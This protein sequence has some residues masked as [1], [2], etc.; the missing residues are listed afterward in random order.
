MEKRLDCGQIHAPHIDPQCESI[1]VAKQ[2]KMGDNPD[3]IFVSESTTTMHGKS[4]METIPHTQHRPICTRANRVAVG[5]PTPYRKRFKLQKTDWNGYATKLNKLIEDVEP[6]PE[7]YSGFIEKLRVASKRYIPRGCRTNYIPC[8]SGKSKS[9][10]KEYKKQYTSDPFDKGT[11]TLMNNM[12]EEKKKKWEEVITT[13]SMAHNSRKEW[14]AIKKGTRLIYP[15]M[16][17]MRNIICS[18][19]THQQKKHDV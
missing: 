2:Y 16:S 5:H 7:K 3:L 10:Y 4:V 8:I 1:Y 6:I 12:K 14:K 19:I 11:N 18:P 13:T 15:S 17:S 9:L